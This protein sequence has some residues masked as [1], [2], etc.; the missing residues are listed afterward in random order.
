MAA[1]VLIA[2]YAVY[3]AYPLEKRIR[4]DAKIFRIDPIGSRNALG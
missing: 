4:L 3:T 1:V 2:L